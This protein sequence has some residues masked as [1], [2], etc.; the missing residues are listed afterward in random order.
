[1][2]QA[3]IAAGRTAPAGRSPTMMQF[4]FLQGAKADETIAY[5]VT[6]L[7]DGKRF[8]SRNVRGAQSGG[9]IVCDAQ[10][11]FSAPLESPSHMGPPPS[12]L[13]EQDPETLP[14]PSQLPASLAA[15]VESVL[16]YRVADV[17]FL[18]MRVRGPSDIALTLLPEP[19]LGFWLKSRRALPD[20]P[21][22]QAAAFAYLS[23]WWINFGSC[24]GHVPATLAAGRRIYVASLNHAIWLHRPPRA[25]EWM[26][27]DCASPSA[28]SG[29][30]FTNARVYDRA[31]RLFASVTQECLVAMMDE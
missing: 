23:D 20:D 14:T 31:G 29:R 26:F 24:G 3:M 7:Q 4:L 1:M 11:T 21:L 22:I 18:D 9:R 28:A 12:G 2:G 5:D 10:V 13:A 8:C 30:G 6:A 27:F 25:D 17:S 16:G 15:E 19:R